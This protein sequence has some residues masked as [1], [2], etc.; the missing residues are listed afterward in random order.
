MPGGDELNTCARRDWPWNMGKN[1]GC[2]RAGVRLRTPP[3]PHQDDVLLVPGCRGGHR[4]RLAQANAA[5]ERFQL[6]LRGAVSERVAD[7]PAA[8][9]V[10]LT[11]DGKVA[12][13][14]AVV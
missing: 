10:A 3:V 4:A 2:P 13:E 1:D 7:A 5:G 6:E 11:L 12:V 14:P 8:A 9:H